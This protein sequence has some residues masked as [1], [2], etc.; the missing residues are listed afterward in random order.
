MV[1]RLLIVFSGLVDRGVFP[2][3]A[4]STLTGPTLGL[5]FD[6][7]VHAIRPIWGIPGSSTAGQPIDLGF[8]LAAAVISPSQDYALVV[9]GDGSMSAVTFAFN[10][11]SLQPITSAAAPDRIVT[12]PGGNSV[13]LYYSASQSVQ[14]LT[15][16]PVSPQMARQVDLSLLPNAPDVIAI[17]DDGALLLV[18]VRENADGSP[19]QGEV[20]VLTP[21]TAAPRSIASVQ[22]ASAIAFVSQS[23]DALLADDVANS[24]TLVSDV[25]NGANVAWAFTSQQL[26]AP[27]SVQASPDRQIF[28]VAS[29]TNSLVAI[30][31]ASGSNAVEVA[32][33]C[34]PA[35]LHPLNEALTYQI[36]E[37]AN[38]LMWILDG[39]MSYPRVFF[40]PIPSDPGQSGAARN[41]KGRGG[42]P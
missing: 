2:G 25:A 5:F 24:V 38:G 7:K 19:A 14:I 35:E 6:P 26:P 17:S 31:D 23:H 16:L 18:G 40:V 34:V 20:F 30:L 15:N 8:P 9:A 4:Q 27:D 13:A 29:S 3:M 11:P 22:H 32:C 41:T 42:R 1:A 28:L 10:G 39:S 21:D 37:P 12:S 33:N 36:T